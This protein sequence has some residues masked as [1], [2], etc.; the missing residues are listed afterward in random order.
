MHE[1]NTILDFG[2]EQFPIPDQW[3]STTALVARW[4]FALPF[5]YPHDGIAHQYL[6]MPLLE[7][8]STGP[9][10]DEEHKAA[11]AAVFA[12]LFLANCMK[13]PMAVLFWADRLRPMPTE[14]LAAMTGET[15][16]N[17]YLAVMAHVDGRQAKEMFRRMNKGAVC[18][19]TG[20]TKHAKDLCLIEFAS[21]VRRNPWILLSL[22]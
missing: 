20:L 4:S 5:V 16:T 11:L 9:L 10:I 7:R 13:W 18:H 3:P 21:R 12:I 1:K 8:F 19:Q 14:V 6:A 2:G 22:V 15:L 17:E